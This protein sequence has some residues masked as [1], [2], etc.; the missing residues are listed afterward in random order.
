[1]IINISNYQKRTYDGKMTYN[2]L[3]KKVKA[4]V[5]KYNTT[6]DTD[7]DIAEFI[8]KSFATNGMIMMYNEVGFYEWHKIMTDM[9]KQEINER[10]KARRW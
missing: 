8:I 4:L 3:Q 2:D 6:S 9:V 10:N 1:M 7:K 5:S